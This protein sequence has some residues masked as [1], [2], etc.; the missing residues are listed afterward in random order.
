MKKQGPNSFKNVLYVEKVTDL[1]WLRRSVDNLDEY[2][3]WIHLCD[4]NSNIKQ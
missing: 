2:S 1:K 4:Q 3:H